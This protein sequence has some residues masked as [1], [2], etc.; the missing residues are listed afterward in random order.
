MVTVPFFT[1]RVYSRPLYHS[2]LV[3]EVILYFQQKALEL[4]VEERG[5]ERAGVLFLYQTPFH[6]SEWMGGRFGPHLQIMR[7]INFL[8]R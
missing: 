8:Y 2:L 5:S 3:V 1:C 4:H 6:D 7:T